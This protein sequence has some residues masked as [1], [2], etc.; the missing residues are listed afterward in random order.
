VAFSPSMMVQ[1]INP[2]VDNN[3]FDP[4]IGGTIKIIS[5]FFLHVR[6]NLE[7]LEE[8]LFLLQLLQDLDISIIQ[9]K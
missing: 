7:Q 6:M 8:M 9:S 1:E 5:C 3:I 2:S 4:G